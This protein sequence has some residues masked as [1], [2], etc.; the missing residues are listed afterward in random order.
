VGKV[1][2]PCFVCGSE[3]EPAGGG[4][5]GVQPSDGTMWSSSGNYGSAVWDDFPQLGDQRHLLILVC[6]GCLRDA[7]A[8]GRVV[9]S[10]ARRSV[11]WAHEPWTADDP[12]PAPTP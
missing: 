10:T 9:L 11:D 12:E 8:R 1:I 2:L 5:G 3:M 6:D 4:D 7:G